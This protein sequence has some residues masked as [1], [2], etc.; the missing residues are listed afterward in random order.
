MFQQAALQISFL[1]VVTEAVQ[2]WGAVYDIKI[3]VQ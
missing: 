3:H 1:K 2:V